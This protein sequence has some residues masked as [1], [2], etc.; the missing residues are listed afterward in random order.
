MKRQK[1]K[2]ETPLRPWDKQRLEEEKKLIRKFGLKN[3]K[4]IWRA[5]AIVRKF[6]RMAREIAATYDKE[7]ERILINKVV[8]LGLLKEG[9]T[10]DDVLGLTVENLLE[11][12]LQTILKNKGLANTIK[13]ARKLITHGHVKIN[14]RKVTYPSYVVPINEEDSIVV[15]KK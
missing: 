6:R 2:Y 9:A 12:R 5:E 10:L 15:D 1:K 4:E 8:R 11:R 13:H 3:K 7:K 14:G